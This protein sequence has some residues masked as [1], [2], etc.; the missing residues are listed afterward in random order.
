METFLNGR[1][2]IRSFQRTNSYIE[3]LLIKY[4]PPS[5]KRV[6]SSRVLSIKGWQLDIE[7]LLRHYRRLLLSFLQENKEKLEGILKI[8]EKDKRKEELQRLLI[9]KEFP[10]KVLL[11]YF[12]VILENFVLDVDIWPP[13]CPNNC[14]YC[15]AQLPGMHKPSYPSRKGNEITVDRKLYKEILEHL[16]FYLKEKYSLTM[17]K[18]VGFGET[19]YDTEFLEDILYFSKQLN[20]WTLIFVAGSFLPNLKGRKPFM[21]Y[22]LEYPVSLMIKMHFVDSE[23]EKAVVRPG[24]T[25]KFPQLRDQLLKE[26]I[27]DGIWNNFEPTRIGIENVLSVPKEI[28][29]T[30]EDFFMEVVPQWIAM[31]YYFGYLNN[32]YLDFDPP[33][34]VGRTTDYLSAYKWA[35]LFDK[36]SLIEFARIVYNLYKIWEDNFIMPSQFFF[37]SPCSQLWNGIYFPLTLN[38]APCCGGFTTLDLLDERV[39]VKDK[40]KW[41]EAL[42]LTLSKQ[43]YRDL[44]L[45]IVKDKNPYML[46][47][48]GISVIVADPITGELLEFSHKDEF[49][50]KFSS[51][52]SAFID[53]ML[54]SSTKGNLSYMLSR[55][56][57]ILPIVVQNYHTC[58]FRQERQLLTDEDLKQII[59]STIKGAKLTLQDFV[60]DTVKGKYIEIPLLWKLTL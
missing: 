60:K 36:H 48:K 44:T 11:E 34:P 4:G 46:F 50:Q 24:R 14:I 3:R 16:I 40:K 9:E 35:G 49:M 22:L 1:L 37:A 28:I 38:I 6:A 57:H 10:T 41:E 18:V 5:Y 29:K 31:I 20:I 58:P 8:N 56:S 33:I 43:K 15:F 27:K 47:S 21:D 52:L 2:D 17:M 45:S 13:H 25:S 54:T 7:I 55:E 26:I 39:F 53:E 23:L 19:L 51:I 42:D 59:I 30:K 12:K 32:F